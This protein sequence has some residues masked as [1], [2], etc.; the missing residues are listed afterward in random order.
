[1]KPTITV[2]MPVFNCEQYIEEAIKCILNQTYTDFEL[3]IIDDA[4]T[5]QSLAKVEKFQDSR[6]KVE[7]Y[8]KNHGLMPFPKKRIMCPTYIN[9]LI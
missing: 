9:I 1:M 8:K 2:L 4:S 5:D 7:S 6:I 3:L